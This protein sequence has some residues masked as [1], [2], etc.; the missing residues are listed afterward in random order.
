MSATSRAGRTMA[1]RRRLL[2]VPLC[3]PAA[4]RTQTL[5]GALDLGNQSD[6]HATITGRRLGL[7]MSEQG[8]NDANVLPALEQMGRK[9][10][11][12]R[13]QRDRLAQ[14]RGFSGLLEQS[15]ELTRGHWLMVTE[16]WKQPALFVRD[17]VV[18][19]GRS[20]VPLLAERLQDLRRQLHGP[21]LAALRLDDAGNL[22]L[23]IDVAC[24]Q[25]FHLAGP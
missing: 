3:T 7:G 22:L 20:H 19:R 9:A 8:L 23:S 14:P 11:A 16:A 12:K 21:V 15:T 2:P 5:Q 1:K 10:V 24:S 13:M 4:R 6:R 18:G 25:P 17:A